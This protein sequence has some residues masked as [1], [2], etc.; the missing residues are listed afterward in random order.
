MDRWD[1]A[2]RL[3]PLMAAALILG[4]FAGAAEAKTKV[5]TS[6]N[7]NQPI[8]DPGD[9]GFG[10][11]PSFKVKTRG[12]VKDVNV[13]VRIS[14]PDARELEIG[15]SHFPAKGIL[16]SVGLK[17]VG[18]LSEPPGADFGS[19]APACTG[20]LF[21]VFDSQASTP[22]FGAPPPFA[23]SFL[24]S[25]SLRPLNGPLE[26]KWFLDLLDAV[27][28]DTGV[29]HCWQITVRYKPAKKRKP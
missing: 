2:R 18:Q 27:P 7:V 3:A 12:T 6:G 23:G 8:P 4:A 13:G 28:G 14:H 1:Q 11:A 29:L 19:G 15:A 21:T 24:P 22:I 17:E 10:I 5:F 9:G 26:G 20:A 16:R 25:T